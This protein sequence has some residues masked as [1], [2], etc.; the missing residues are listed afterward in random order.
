MTISPTPT[1]EDRLAWELYPPMAA[2]A[3]MYGDEG[4]RYAAFLAKADPG[5]AAEPYFLWNQPLAGGTVVGNTGIPTKNSTR[6]TADKD[7]AA[8][9]GR[10]LSSWLWLGAAVFTLLSLL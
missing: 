3:S 8:A 6:T 9:S 1:G 5:Y 10:T 4:G 2:V 7:N